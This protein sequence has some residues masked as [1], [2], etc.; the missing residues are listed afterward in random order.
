LIAIATTT[1]F[2]IIITIPGNIFFR[3]FCFSKISKNLATKTHV[4]KL[5]IEAIRPAA[6][7]EIP[8]I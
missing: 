4:E 6:L 3:Y 8:G 7:V 1:K 5:Y 2:I